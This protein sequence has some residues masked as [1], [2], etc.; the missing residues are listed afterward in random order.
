MVCR[1]QDHPLYSQYRY[2]GLAVNPAFAGSRGVPNVAAL[3]RTHLPKTEGAPV[4]QTLAGDFPMINPKLALGLL[5]IN[6]KVGIYKRMGFYGAYAFRVNMQQGKLSFGIQ[7]GFE[8]M[9][10]D[11]SEVTVMEEGDRMFLPGMRRVFM[12]NVGAGMYYD[13]PRCFAGLS[14]PQLIRY[15]DAG[16]GA[17]K[18][19]PALSNVMLYGGMLLPV[20]KHVRLKPSVLLRFEQSGLLVD[21]NCNVLLLPDDR[22]EVGLSC[23]STNVL[24][25]MAQ[26]KINSRLCIGYAY[27]HALKTAAIITGAHEIMLRY[28]FNFLVKAENPLYLKQ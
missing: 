19:A 17:Y 26:I 4:T 16:A 5:M 13:A 24:A 23:R 11:A 8:Q 3:Y 20:N 28:E 22:L 27:D 10:E 14:V 21:V 25:A 9:R 2:N 7:G 12:P 6:D 15:A 18:G 1:S